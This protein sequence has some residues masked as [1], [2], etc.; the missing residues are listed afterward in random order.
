MIGQTISHYKILEQIG[1]G[2]MGVVYRAHDD[3]L[4]RDVALKVLAPD[5]AGDQEFIA[6]FR[7]EARTLSK[8]NHPNVATVHDFDTEVDTSFIV[9]ELIRGTS[10]VDKIRNGP[11]SERDLVR[12]ALQL[13]DGLCAAHSEGIIHRDLKPGNLRETLD[14]RLKILDFGLARTLDT[15][16]EATTSVATTSGMV[17]T[18]PYMAPE[19][20]RGETV[21]VR[22][23]I[24]SVGVV[25]YELATASRP[26]PETFGPRLIDCILH[27]NPPSARELNPRVSPEFEALIRKAMERDPDCRYPSA[28]QMRSA[29]QRIGKPDPD[30]TTQ[31]DADFPSHAPPME[32]AHVLFTDIVGYSKL[33]MD[34]QQRHLRHLQ[35]LV[36]STAEFERAKAS[37]QLITLPSGDGMALVFFGEP[38]APARCAM[39]LSKSLRSNLEIKLRMGINSGP[40]YRVADINANRN[41]AGGGINIA[42]RVMDCGDA[43]HILISKSVADVLGQLSSWRGHLHDLGEVEVKH[44]VRVHIFNLLTEESGNPAT[45]E[46]IKTQTG[47]T[48]KT[49]TLPKKNT[50]IAV[51]AVLLAAIVGAGLWAWGG[52]LLG[53]NALRPTVAVLG[54][55]NQTGAPETDWVSTS[56][57][58]MLA[59]ELAAGDLVVPTAGESVARMKIDLALPN[60]ASYAADTIQ[61]VRRALNCDYVVY[62]GFFDSGKSAGGRVQLNLQ[63]RRAKSGE[64]LAEVSED[65]TELA[66]PELAAQVGSRLRAKLGLPGINPSQSSQ[67]RAAVPST[68]EAT[69]LYFDGLGRL[70]T[71]DLLGAKESLTKATNADPNFSL[72]HAYLAEA[73]SGLG[74]DD[75]AKAEAKTAFDLSSHLAREDKTLVEARYREIFSQWDSATDLYRS[76]WILY[77]ENFE[78]A[79]R[80]ADAQIRAG[81]SADALKTIAQL[82]EQPDSA[83]PN[84]IAKDPRL[85]LKEAEAAEAVSDFTKEKLAAQRAAS[86]ANAR[87]SRLL[88][89]EALW[90]ACAAMSLLGEA[91][92]AQTACSQSIA[93][94]K[95]VGDLLLTAR[96]YTILGLIAGTQGDLKQSLEQH[97][98][99]LTYARKIGSR[100]DI[101][102][103]L[104]NIG[105]VLSTEGDLAAAQ[106]SYENALAEAQEINDRG[107]IVNILNNLATVNQTLGKFSVALHL[108]EQ[109]LAEAQAL[110]DKG[111][112]ARAQYN[113]A[114]I[115]SLQGD[116]PS[117]L[118]NYQQSIRFAEETGNKNDQAQFLNGLGDVQLDQNDL[119]AAEDTYRSALNLA[120][121]IGD[122]SSIALGRA[123]LARLKLRQGK[124][125]EA[126]VLA[127]QS[128]DEYQAEDSKDMESGAR[129]LLASALLEL[130][131]PADAAA[132]LDRVAKLA[133]QDPTLKLDVAI[134]AARL[135]LRKGS[136]AAGKIQLDHVA[137]D[138]SKLGVVAL[139][140]E[141]RL[142]QGELA[143]FGGDKRT[144]LAQLSALQKDAARKGYRLIEARAR[145]ISQQI[146]SARTTG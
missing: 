6:R 37:N 69:R 135:Q 99:A 95:P 28:A 78:Y 54:F 33:A 56:L 11:L 49:I 137:S 133:P 72:A 18:L 9:M 129:N 113:M 60:E 82:R 65:G 98:Q 119:A 100:R 101:A 44:G 117:A 93:I 106:Q 20:L 115:Y 67:L 84:S 112:S 42:Q 57:S 61:K 4:D 87:G 74:Y 24:Y 26:F 30:S 107:Q 143:L 126:E 1:A 125:A 16:L 128:A 97:R 17:G 121:N 66:L 70:R 68:P 52:R 76:L 63:M 110:Q 108:Y 96:A 46:K 3:R 62:G 55:K 7:R 88:E 142:A 50:W 131:R 144:A 45:P 53:R 139:Q 85:D 145:Q 123:S 39:E 14:G 111:S 127:R 13:L 136:I 83:S 94:S 79:I 71:F 21:D 80:A 134:T 31:V 105:N 118:R 36:R 29:L 73:W 35:K 116:F 81:K 59:A 51:A 91:Q 122:K 43:G 130:D 138:A 90:R 124:F 58:D 89:G 32:I 114:F 86:G 75:N 77:P 19:Q 25:L 23:D 141:A 92:N 48:Q 27:E 140:F 104:N 109:S 41:V 15:D 146:S 120:T 8:L 40:V 132:E 5:L 102:G 10:L 47:K 34:E 2:G 38:E 22:T 12:L 64:L 103:A